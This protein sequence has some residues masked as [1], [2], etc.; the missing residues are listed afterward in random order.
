MVDEA[1]WECSRAPGHTVPR[2][3]QAIIAVPYPWVEGETH[4]LKL[5]S[6]TGPTFEHTIEV[7]TATPTVD[8]RY[9]ATFTLLGIYVG[10]IPAL[11]GLLWFPFLRPLDQRGFAFFLSLTA[12]LRLFLG[13]EAVHDAREPAGTPPPAFR[14]V[15]LLLVRLL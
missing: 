6:S 10:V 11:L 7:A 13:A 9:L 2:L 15:G 12:G 5:I 14:G 3:G 4:H 8:A 1:Y